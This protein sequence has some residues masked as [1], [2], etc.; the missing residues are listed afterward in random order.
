MKRTKLRVLCLL[1]SLA[2]LL[3]ILPM[4]VWAKEDVYDEIEEIINDT[5]PTTVMSKVNTKSDAEDWLSGKWW[6]SL[7][8]DLY[9]TLD[10]ADI[11]PG[12]LRFYLDDFDAAIPKNRYDTDGTVGS[13]IVVVA[14]GGKVLGH[15]TLIIEPDEWGRPPKDDDDDDDDNVNFYGDDD[16]AVKV[17]W[18]GDSSANRPDGL[19]IRLYKNDKLYRTRTVTGVKWYAAWDN[20]EE[21]KYWSIDVD[22]PD[23]YVCDIEKVT[24][25]YFEVTMTKKGA[26]ASTSSSSAAGDKVNPST[27]AF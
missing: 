9:D 17:Y 4:T 15:T 20:V 7:K 1:L 19:L 27:G 25:D 11:N 5:V 26:S 16:L 12:R 6:S 10:E 18:K 13:A 8:K 14:A 22:V 21:S 24:D 2:M 23:G 3:S